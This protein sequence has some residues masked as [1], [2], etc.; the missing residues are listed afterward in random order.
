[1]IHFFDERKTGL[2]LALAFGASLTACSNMETSGTSEEA[3]GVVATLDKKI[4]GVSQKG[5]FVKGSEVTLREASDDGNFEPTGREFVVKT[6]NDEGEFRFDSLD[7]ESP[8]VRVSVEGRYHHERNSEI[9]RCPMR[10]EAV[11]N[12]EKRETVNINLLTHFE[13]KRVLNLIKEGKSFAEAKKQAATEVLEAF[14]VKIKASSA[15]DLNIYNTSDADRTLYNISRIIDEDPRW[16][17]WYSSLSDDDIEIFVDFAPKNSYE[18][19]CSKL[20]V[21][22]DGFADDFADDG[23]LDDT[24]MQS[25]AG[26]AY[27][28]ATIFAGRDVAGEDNV[29]YVGPVF[30]K[31]VYD[32]SVQLF[33]HYMGFEPC[34]EELWGEYRG[35]DKPIELYGEVRQSGYALCNGFYWRLTT[36]EHIDSLKANVEHETGTMTDPR[37]GR[38]YKTVSFEY[39]GKKYEWMAEDLK[40]DS[41]GVYHWTKAMQIEDKYMGIVVKNDLI[42]S[43]HQGI[44]PDGWHVSNTEEWKKLIDYAGG[45]KNLL[46][47]TWKA[48]D[49]DVAYNKGLVDVFFNKLDLNFTPMNAVYLKAYYHSYAPNSY[50]Y[51]LADAKIVEMYPYLSEEEQK[52][53]ADR[54]VS[55]PAGDYAVEIST[56]G[57][58]VKETPR[59]DARV[60]CVKN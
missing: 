24:L 2:V 8:Y 9:S 52:A 34:T 10:L 7:L 40:Y 15:E 36:E 49:E 11:S 45:V 6:F 29:S 53:L 55:G 16:N 57:Y 51:R 23:A 46:N 59:T 22:I 30:E 56:N 48:S 14:G 28:R 18:I 25:L 27:Y 38:K 42:D 4:A 13:H 43:V 44:C 20:Q 5:P 17:E 1:M 35:F 26:N 37:D 58:L 41:D 31:R 19:D 47:E 39:K 60:R 54:L 3:E 21:Y 50:R 33:L 32:F 12:L